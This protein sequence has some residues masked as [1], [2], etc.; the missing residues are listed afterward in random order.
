MKHPLR[1]TT[2]AATI[3]L[4]AATAFAQNTTPTPG[5]TDAQRPTVH[6]GM[7][8]SRADRSFVEKAAQGGMAE[9][10]LGK[11][12]QQKASNEQ[13]RQFGAQLVSDHSRANDELRQVAM[14]RGIKLPS[15][16]GRKHH[17]AMQ[18]MS[19]LSGAKFDR[20]FMSHMV[21]DHKQDIAEFRKEADSG[22]DSQLKAFAN[23]TLPTLEQHL[24]VARDVQNMVQASR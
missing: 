13:V 24:R 11:L 23:K 9:V 22:S 16:M 21:D 20:E 8:V 3:C 17:S 15:D 12:A 6:S 2:V 5:A 14:D 7:Q 19:K 1:L 4:S 10:E 18:R